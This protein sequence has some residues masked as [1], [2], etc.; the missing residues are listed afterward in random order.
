MN[1]KTPIYFILG[2]VAVYFIV[3]LATPKPTLTVDKELEVKIETLSMQLEELKTQ[4]AALY[5][6]DSTLLIE[7]WGLD[8]N[9]IEIKRKTDQ[10]GIKYSGV[11]AATTK[12]TPTQVDSFYKQRYKY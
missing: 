8:D 11:A 4:Q 5:S 7:V 10:I 2:L 9:I 3:V 1:L 6:T 12:Y